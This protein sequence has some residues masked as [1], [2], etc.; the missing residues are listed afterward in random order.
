MIIAAAVG[1]WRRRR[2][3][4]AFLF[5]L[6][7]LLTCW[8]ETMG[9]WGQHLVYS[10]S[11]A[12]YSWDWL[13]Y[14]TV[15]EPYFMPFAYAIYWTIHAWAIL[16]LAQW[17][18]NRRGWSLLTAVIVW[19]VPVT[20]LWDI[21][22]ETLSA[23]FGWWTYN[24]GFG[25]VIAFERGRQPLLWPVTLMLFWP[26]VV[27]YLAGKPVNRGLNRIELMFRL[28]RWTRPRTPQS[29]PV[30]VIVTTKPG[31]TAMLETPI[32]APITT[33]DDGLNYDVVG[34]SRWKFE[35]A[36]FG[37]WTAVFQLSFFILLVV[38]LVFLR[39]VTGHNSIYVP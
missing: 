16:T 26:N 34:I 22:A 9:D 32:Q 5:L 1:C 38:P 4:W 12:H 11:F 6:S 35:L 29:A 19:S 20:F 24:P 13:P 3:T 31:G 36:R 2:L 28:D 39:L 18:V 23:Y 30:A 15:T 10:P 14:H 33:T 27:A 21:S 7:S 37:A 25:P 17:L 8:M